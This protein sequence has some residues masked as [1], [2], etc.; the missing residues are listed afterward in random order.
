[1]ANL[2]SN[3]KLREIIRKIALLNAL[4]HGGKAQTGPVPGKL[5]A[6]DPHLK[7]RAKEVASIIAEVVQEVNKLSP[8][9]QREIVEE[10]WPK[11][12]VKEKAEVKR[13]LPSL[14]NAENYSVSKSHSSLRTTLN[15]DF[16]LLCF[17]ILE[18]G[19]K[20]FCSYFS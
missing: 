9:K 12:L 16:S 3:A 19:L 7:T 1:M 13:I 8:D 10:K 14:P 11:A 2:T 17:Y 18:V 4:S 20:L 6:E 15:V 5:L